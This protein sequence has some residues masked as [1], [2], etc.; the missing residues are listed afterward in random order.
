[1]TD[2]YLCI[3]GH[4]Y[5]PPRENPWLDA[6]ELEDSAYPW[7][8]WNER[9]AAECYAPNA[10]SRILDANDR[11]KRIVSN[12]ASISFD[13]GP[14]LLSW[15]EAHDL[16]TY[17]EILDADRQSAVRFSGHGSAMAQAYNHMIMPLANR[18]DKITQIRWGIR[19]F[20]TRFGREPEGMWLP[21]TAADLETLELLA[22][23]GVRFVVLAPHQ[24][25]RVRKM[26]ETKWTDLHGSEIDPS[27]PYRVLLE[28]GRELAA[29]FY[30]GP[31]SRAVA[32]EKL[33]TRGEWL[34]E[35][36]QTA[37]DGSRKRPQLASIATDG[38]TYGHHHRRGD[39]AL[40]W[41]IHVIE[42]RSLARLTNYAEFLALH[43]PGSEVEIR[44]NT[45]WSCNHGI[46]RWRSDCGCHTGGEAHWS[47]AWRG[48]LR[49]AL[50]WLRDRLA[51]LYEEAGARLFLDPWE[52]RNNYIDLV[53][54]R[55]LPNVIRFFDSQAGHPLDHAERVRALELLEMQRH[56]MLMY[57][58]CGWFFNDVSGI[59]TIQIL[60]Y[61][62]RAVQLA[63]RL[64][65]Q[66]LEEEFLS[67]LAPAR[68]NLAIWGDARQVY[69]RAVKPRSVDLAR[70]G[71]HHA[72]GSLFELSPPVRSVYCYKLER[73]AC[74]TIEAGRAKVLYGSMNVTSE[75]TRESRRFSFGLLYLGDIHLTGGICPFDSENH[76][77]LVREL[78]ESRALSDFAAVMHTL[79]RHL[80]GLTFSLESVF[81]DEQRAIL[82][83]ICNTTLAEAEAALR[84]LHDRYLPLM[85]LHT[86]LGIPLPRVL[87][88]AAEFDL[89]LLLR[90][91]LE[92][93]ELSIGL[94]EALM[95]KVRTESVPLDATSLA[96]AL[97]GT[98]E[99][100]ASRFAAAPE[101]FATIRALDE[102]IRLARILPFEV[103]LWKAQN[104]HY[105]VDESLVGEIRQRAENGDEAAGDWIGAY[106][107][108]RTNLSL[109]ERDIRVVS[110]APDSAGPTE[111][112]LVVSG[113]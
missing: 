24:A 10:A 102:A 101:N 81:R 103:D 53:L 30:D 96:F 8:D 108:L 93:E 78:S 106:R 58:S 42:S 44:E 35:R 66:P 25:G 19:D 60:Q 11:I 34:A 91:A 6:V 71:A 21:E 64:F 104:A 39:M 37:F 57:T 43:P 22:E 18:R 94:I 90:R 89:N 76:A 65:G 7:H 88:V 13:F 15:L 77:S 31:I 113:S 48:P 3:H 26:G 99:K 61:A 85:R 82:G 28:S 110:A 36:M 40:A 49:E 100:I 105:R 45:S 27:V 38:E 69:E 62:A 5:Q 75:I 32:F 47:Q 109:S 84:Q 51:P 63:E 4:F 95:A 80:G 112:P 111:S 86:D 9:I 46:E 56:A 59:E 72:V 79:E 16:E 87:S 17:R 97:E 83:T 1:L 20:V 55:S 33:L 54:D 12:Y 14:T 41:A 52:A 67:R 73:E 50:D 107:S 92:Q 2:R 23:E 29:F 98:I 74:E 68:S 70:V